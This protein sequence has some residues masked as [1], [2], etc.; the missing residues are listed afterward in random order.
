MLIIILF[1]LNYPLYWRNYVL[2]IRIA[3]LY[4]IKVHIIVK[5]WDGIGNL[6]IKR[7]ISS[8]NNYCYVRFAVKVIYLYNES[9][10]ILN[11]QIPP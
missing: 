11:V 1:I 5:L 10:V 6:N 9:G 4:Q 8:C 3:L 7:A 2:S